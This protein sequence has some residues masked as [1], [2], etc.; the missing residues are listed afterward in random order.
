MNLGRRPDLGL[1]LN[2][3]GGAVT[4]CVSVLEQVGG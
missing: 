1:V 2:M 3:G 4:S